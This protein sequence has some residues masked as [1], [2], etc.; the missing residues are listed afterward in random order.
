KFEA[1]LGGTDILKKEEIKDM[2]MNL[3][4]RCKNFRA[5][6]HPPPP[7][8]KKKGGYV[9]PSPFF[10]GEGRKNGDGVW[11]GRKKKPRH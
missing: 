10:F 8:K 7:P 1:G 9:K 2:Q 3:Y 6:F 5:G 11:D 4:Q